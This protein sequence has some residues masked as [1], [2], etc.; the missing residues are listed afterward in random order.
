MGDFDL[1]EMRFNVAAAF[2]DDDD[3][4]TTLGTER[5][6]ETTF[7][8]G[9]RFETILIRLA[10]PTATDKMLKLGFSQS[11][12]WECNLRSAWPDW[13][14]YWTLVTI[15]FPKYPTFLGNFCEGVK[16]NHF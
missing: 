9:W 10:T 5:R 4:V 6:F 1:D 2:D 15:N 11:V 16:I 3:D 13:A 14:I 12:D 7:G 8:V